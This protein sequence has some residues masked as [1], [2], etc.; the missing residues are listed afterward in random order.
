[1]RLRRSISTPPIVDS[2]W[3]LQSEVSAVSRTDAHHPYRSRD[4]YLRTVH[5]RFG[6]VTAAGPH[7]RRRGLLPLPNDADDGCPRRTRDHP[8]VAAVDGLGLKGEHGAS[9]GRIGECLLLDL[10]QVGV[11]TAL[12][13]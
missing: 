13:H 1:M 8:R 10:E 12:D 11:G 6:P 3:D 2:V 4:S 9:V 7:L 5:K